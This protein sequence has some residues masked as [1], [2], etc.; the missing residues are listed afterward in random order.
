MMTTVVDYP[1][2]FE[3]PSEYDPICDARPAPWLARRVVEI[4]NDLAASWC[5]VMAKNDG[6]W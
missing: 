5:L 2:A 1:A 3:V 4:R 6:S